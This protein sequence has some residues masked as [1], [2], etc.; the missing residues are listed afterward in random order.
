MTAWTAAKADGWRAAAVRHLVQLGKQAAPDATLSIKWG[1]P[2]FE[3]HGPVA[4][5]KV[6]KAHVTFGF[7]RGA[8]L[9]DDALEGG[10]QMRHI[11]IASVDEIDDVRVTQLVRKAVDLNR[12]HGDPTKRRPPA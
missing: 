10:A 12:L 2:V 5:I 8:Q 4:F 6:A 11:K 3:D 9:D 7:W 1:Q